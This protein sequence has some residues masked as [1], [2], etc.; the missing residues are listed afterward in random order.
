ML[1]NSRKNPNDLTRFIEK[2]TTDTHGEVIEKYYTLDKAKINEEAMYD[3]F[4]AITM[5]LENE[6]V[7][8]I[9][10]ISERR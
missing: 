10:S 8:A 6:D 5:N 1:K 9:I 2:I 7:K 4:Y 3:G